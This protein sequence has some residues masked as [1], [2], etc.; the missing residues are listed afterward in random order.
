MPLLRAALAGAARLREALGDRLVYAYRQL[1]NERV[2]P[3]AEYMSRAAEAA[4]DARASSGRCT[5]RCSSARR[6]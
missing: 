6:R 1:P 4:P 3:G 5:M 2:H